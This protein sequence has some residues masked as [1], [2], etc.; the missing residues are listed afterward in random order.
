MVARAD[1]PAS[2]KGRELSHITPVSIFSAGTRKK[3]LTPSVT[4]V[5][6]P[7]ARLLLILVV[8]DGGGG[9]RRRRFGSETRFFTVHRTKSVSC[10]NCSLK[11]EREREN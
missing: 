6:P 11:E 4:S 10:R 1:K 3:A 9:G 5:S 7:I 2:I 8:A